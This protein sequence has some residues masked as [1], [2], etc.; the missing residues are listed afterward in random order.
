MGAKGFFR[1]SVDIGGHVTTLWSFVPVAVQTAITG[2]L[3]AV[4][5]YFG[6]YEVGIARAIFYAS[7]VLVFGMTFVFL[8][9]R[10]ASIIG[11]FR[12]LSIAAFQVPNAG[13]D[14][15]KNGKV[16]SLSGLNAQMVLRNDS[17]QL[18][19]YRLRRTAHS[20]EGK[21]PISPGTDKSVI[22][23][24]PNGG[25]QVVNFATIEGIV[26]SSKDSR[27]KG[28]V[29]VE[30]EYGSSMD[31]LDYLFHYAADYQVVFTPMPGSNEFRIDQIA[32]VRALEHSKI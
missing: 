16:L 20:L 1:R 10:I 30:V 18:M 11:I 17:Q 21:V 31:D 15:S 2:A 4:T 19:Y 9:L 3:T 24:P 25:M 22:I 7:G 32:S 27:F 23:I 6:Y 26:T 13:V 8:W 5:A 14:K 29:D 12:R 28:H